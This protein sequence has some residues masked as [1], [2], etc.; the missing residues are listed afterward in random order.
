MIII[1]R[2]VLRADCIF[3]YSKEN[4]RI[5]MSIDAPSWEF[6]FVN[7][8]TMQIIFFIIFSI[9]KKRWL[10]YL[11]LI[12]FSAAPVFFPIFLIQGFRYFRT[13]GYKRNFE[14]TSF[15][16]RRN[17]KKVLDIENFKKDSSMPITCFEYFCSSMY[18]DKC[19]CLHY[20]RVTFYW[21]TVNNMPH[22]KKKKCYSCYRR[23]DKKVLKYFPRI[24]VW[25]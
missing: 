11:K 25:N 3:F 16:H 10:Q 8:E 2:C 20:N 12:L 24:I 1:W 7:K 13:M 18:F 23:S 9:L 14:F 4:N 22:P 15:V 21:M 17:P 19:V 5:Q 6:F